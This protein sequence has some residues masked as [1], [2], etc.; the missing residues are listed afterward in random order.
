MEVQPKS[1]NAPGD[2]ATNLAKALTATLGYIEVRV[3]TEEGHICIGGPPDSGD[4]GISIVI[5]PNSDLGLDPGVQD[6]FYFGL[7]RS[8]VRQLLY[9]FRHGESYKA[10]RDDTQVWMTDGRLNL[11]IQ[12][13]HLADAW[14][15]CSFDED[16]SESMLE[17]F[18]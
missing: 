12:Y 16:S 3:L 5:V 11:R 17:W 13:Q 6:I 8:S 7:R 14:L 4:L 10:R 1:Q 2:Y 18:S 15:H 9:K